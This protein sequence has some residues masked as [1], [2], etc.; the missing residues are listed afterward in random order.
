MATNSEP[1]WYRDM[2]EVEATGGYMYD[3]GFGAVPEKITI[4]KP[5]PDG[6][7]LRSGE[8]E[9]M[10]CTKEGFWVRGVKVPQDDKEAEAVYNA[11]KQWLTWA[12]INDMR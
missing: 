12:T 8:D 7:T 9:M 10:K 2:R 4:R 1:K 5:E 11:F 3:P 6:I